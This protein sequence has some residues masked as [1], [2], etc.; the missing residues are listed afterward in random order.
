LGDEEGFLVAH[1]RYRQRRP[2][3]A[4]S[5]LNG[6]LKPVLVKVGFGVVSLALA[7]TIWYALIFG[8]RYSGANFLQQAAFWISPLSFTGWITLLSLWF[9]LYLGLLKLRTEFLSG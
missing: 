8:L 6:Q 5:L 4:L 7:I 3:P 1:L 2:L 9:L